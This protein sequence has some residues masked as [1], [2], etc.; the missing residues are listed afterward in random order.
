MTKTH[1]IWLSVIILAVIGIF[2]IVN[3][4]L[5]RSTTLTLPSSYVPEGNVKIHAVLP[6]NVA[7]EIYQTGAEVKI[8]G[9]QTE[10]IWQIPTS[11]VARASFVELVSDSG[12]YSCVYEIPAHSRGLLAQLAGWN[13]LG[14]PQLVACADKNGA[15]NESALSK[16]AATQPVGLMVNGGAGVLVKNGDE[17]TAQDIKKVI[18]ELDV[19]GKTEVIYMPGVP[20][21]GTTGKTGAQ[22]PK[23]DAGADGKNGANGA[24]GARGAKGATGATGAQGLKGDTGATGAQ[25]ATG[26]AGATGAQGPAG[27][28]GPAGSQGIQGPQGPAGQDSVSGLNYK[29]VFDSGDTYDKN[30]TVLATAAG[31][32]THTYVCIDPSGCLAGGDPTTDTVSWAIIA[33]QGPTGATGAQGPTGAQGIQGDPGVMGV[34]G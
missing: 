19:I 33:F 4:I 2:L 13:R 3:F 5:G 34:S 7:E 27:T 6:E 25:G 18:E 30:D 9:D 21:A 28:Q 20:Q 10:I 16:V 22:G 15:D 17:I 8:S 32:D 14:Q 1:K 31:G 12:K 26:P 23:G 24:T 29:G 11:E